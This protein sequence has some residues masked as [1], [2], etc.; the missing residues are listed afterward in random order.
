NKGW[1]KVLNNLAFE[2]RLT[3]VAENA[4]QNFQAEVQTAIEEIGNELQII[5]QLQG[6][7]FQFF[8]QDSGFFDKNFVRMTGMV[9]VA[10]GAILAFV[11]PPLGLLSIVG[12][13]TSWLASQFKS[14]EQKRHEAVENISISLRR[15]LDE[16]QEKVMQQSRDN[17]AKYCQSIIMTV[18][19]Y[20][21]ELVQGIGAI[22]NHLNTAQDKLANAANYLNRAYAKRIIDWA[23]DQPESL[24]DTTIRQKICKVNRNFG[25]S[26]EIQTTTT[27]PL[28]KF[29]DEICTVLQENVTIQPKKN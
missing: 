19:D 16:Q 17:F 18:D 15:Q 5:N 14:R 24:T 22:A 27:L 11:F 21:E 4:S 1:E 3:A 28:T 6:S 8:E 12:S 13:V 7:K 23:T 29:Q 20:F 25:H 26:M 2:T 10:A 9:M